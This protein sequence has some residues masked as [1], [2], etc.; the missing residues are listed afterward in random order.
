[1]REYEICLNSG[2]TLEGEAEN[3][4]LNDLLVRWMD[5]RGNSDSIKFTDKEGCL[6]ALDIKNITALILK[7]PKNYKNNIGFKGGTQTDDTKKV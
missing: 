2:Q 4:I 3:P 7:G 6:V 1:M 5:N